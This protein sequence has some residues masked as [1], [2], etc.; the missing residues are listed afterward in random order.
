MRTDRLAIA[1][2]AALHLATILI[3]VRRWPVGDALGPV[4][5]V[6]GVFFEE[7]ACV[8]C[9]LFCGCVRRLLDDRA[10]CSISTSP[11]PAPTT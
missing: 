4:V 5:D 11:R 1:Y 8:G 7:Y 6:E 10:G 2:Q 9:C 3:R